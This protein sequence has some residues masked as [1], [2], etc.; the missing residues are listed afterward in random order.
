LKKVNH[1]LLRKVTIFHKRFSDEKSVFSADFCVIFG[2]RWT[3]LGA[4]KIGRNRRN[5]MKN[6]SKIGAK[7]GKLYEKSFKNRQKSSMENIKE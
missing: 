7:I 1:F 4:S 6:F 2:K 3:F 5:Y